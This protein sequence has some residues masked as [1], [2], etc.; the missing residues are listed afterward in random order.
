[1]MQQKTVISQPCTALRKNSQQQQQL[2]I[3]KIFPKELMPVLLWHSPADQVQICCPTPV[4]LWTAMW[5]NVQQWKTWDLA[6]RQFVG[7]PSSLKRARLAVLEVVLLEV[8]LQEV[9]LGVAGGTARGAGPLAGS[10]LTSA[11]EPEEWQWWQ[12][13]LTGQGGLVL[14][15]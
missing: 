4:A 9:V 14:I 7:S 3:W 12:Q 2:P 6:W 10:W 5:Q 11:V 13:Q 8:V 15:A 1:M